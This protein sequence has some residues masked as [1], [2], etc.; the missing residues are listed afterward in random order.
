LCRTRTPPDAAPS[1]TLAARRLHFVTRGV[2]RRHLLRSSQ[3][4]YLRH[5]EDHCLHQ[6]P[7]VSVIST[8]SLLP[9]SEASVRLLSLDKL[10][11]KSLSSCCHHRMR[12]PSLITLEVTRFLTLAFFHSVLKCRFA[13]PPFHTGHHLQV[14][15]IYYM[16]VHYAIRSVIQFTVNSAHT[17]RALKLVFGST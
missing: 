13:R 5:Q 9:C 6:Y 2:S 8:D 15:N 14:R 17:H 4:P 16:V 3:P 7:S 12:S 10:L 11:V 1:R